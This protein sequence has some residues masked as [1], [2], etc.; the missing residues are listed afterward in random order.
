MTLK[1]QCTPDLPNLALVIERAQI[2]VVKHRPAF[3]A[4]DDPF[5][6]GRGVWG[7]GLPFVSN[8]SA[9]PLVKPN[10]ARI[11]W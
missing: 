6:I 7:A 2:N 8:R 3:L 5:R 11:W 9:T 10:S 4:F 1:R